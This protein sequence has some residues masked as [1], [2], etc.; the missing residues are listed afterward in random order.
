[1][2]GFSLKFWVIYSLPRILPDNWKGCWWVGRLVVGNL[3]V[4]SSQSAASTTNAILVL[5]SILPKKHSS[6]WEIEL[7]FGLGLK[8]W[9]IYSRIRIIQHDWNCVWCVLRLLVGNLVVISSQ[10]AATTNAILVLYSILPKKYSF[11]WEI[12]WIFGFSLKFWVIYSIP[13]IIPDD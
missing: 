11:N 2:I 13:R 4:I 3:M 10:S 1:M 9:V 8:F 5:F 7:I 12:E 6:N